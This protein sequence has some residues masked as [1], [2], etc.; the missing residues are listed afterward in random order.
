MLRKEREKE[1]RIEREWKNNNSTKSVWTTEKQN[2]KHEEEEEEEE[3]LPL[4]QSSVY[5]SHLV[6]SPFTNSLDFSCCQRRLRWTLVQYFINVFFFTYFSLQVFIFYICY[7]KKHDMFNKCL[8]F[9]KNSYTMSVHDVWP[10]LLL[11]IYCFVHWVMFGATCTLKVQ[12]AG[13]SLL[14][15]CTTLKMFDFQLKPS[16]AFHLW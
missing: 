1:R 15:V 5:H 12:Y 7:H 16:S 2:Q 6:S 11:W 8:F 4:R 9:K 13:T 3:H 10:E 14:M